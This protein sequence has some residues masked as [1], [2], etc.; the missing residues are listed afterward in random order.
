MAQ[1]SAERSD[2]EWLRLLLPKRIV[3]SVPGMEQIK[4]MK[5]IVWKNNGVKLTLDV[6]LPPN[7]SGNPQ[8]PALIFIHGGPLPPNLRTEPK[9]WGVYISYGQ[10]AAASDFVGITF[11]HRFYGWNRLLDAQND[12]IDL[13][14]Y[15]RTNAVRLGIDPDRI[16]LWAFSGGGPLLGRVLRDSPPYI[17]CL[18]A[19]YALLDP[20]PSASSTGPEGSSIEFSPLQQLKQ[21]GRAVPPLFIAKAGLDSPALN[22]K[23]DLFVQEALKRNVTIDFSN[24]ASGRH[25]FDILND[26]ERTREIIRRTIEFIRACNR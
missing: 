7:K 16:T 2:P 19:Y 26:D 3:Y 4:P 22:G 20:P 5:D 21:K 15:L 9:D 1:E 24:H 17:R 13:I 25:A 23:L 6:Y 10:L 12:L 11:N 14:T 18:V 8:R